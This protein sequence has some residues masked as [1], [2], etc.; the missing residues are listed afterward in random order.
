MKK[1]IIALF[2][3]A[4]FFGSAY[5]FISNDFETEGAEISY[6]RAI[7]IF[8]AFFVV[9]VA[10]QF[11]MM[12]RHEAQKQVQGSGSEVNSDFPVEEF[13]RTVGGE[14]NIEAVDFEGTRLKITL[15]DV[16]D[17]DQEALKDL[18]PAGA[19]LA[20]NR[21]QINNV[22]QVESVANEIKNIV[23]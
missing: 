20:G 13:V 19:S 11:I 8:I 10:M 3:L 1:N 15:V 14:N 4:F 12:K 9:G 21:L 23:A 17:I 2:F 5:F 7:L 22:V 18:V 6:D 16:D